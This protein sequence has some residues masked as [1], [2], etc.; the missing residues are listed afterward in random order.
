[1][2]RACGVYFLFEMVLARAEQR[3]AAQELAQSFTTSQTEQLEDLQAQLT[4]L[5]VRRRRRR[6]QPYA[7]FALA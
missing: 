1:M 5:Q 3:R 2:A 6:R 7:P 4:E